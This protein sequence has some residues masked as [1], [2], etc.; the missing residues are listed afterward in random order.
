[1]PAVAIIDLFDS[2]RADFRPLDMGTSKHATRAVNIGICWCFRVLLRFSQD[3]HVSSSRAVCGL[4]RPVRGHA[5]PTHRLSVFT[6]QHSAPVCS[7]ASLHIQLS[8]LNFFLMS[9]DPNLPANRSR[10][11]S[12]ELRNQFNGL[13]GF[14]DPVQPQITALQIQTES[15]QSLIASLQSQSAA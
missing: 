15:Q 11:R 1:M 10:I 12:A 4:A 3:G 5:R 7:L 14:I 9:F 2:I 8:T 6:P 13:K